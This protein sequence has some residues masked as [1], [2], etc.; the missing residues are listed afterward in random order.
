MRRYA[1]VESLGVES[2]GFVLEGRDDGD[3]SVQTIAQKEVRSL[4]LGDARVQR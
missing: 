4:S 1:L 3:Q 2:S